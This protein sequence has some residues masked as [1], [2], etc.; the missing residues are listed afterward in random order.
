[1]RARH[2][3]KYQKN[4]IYVICRKN[5]VSEG[6]SKKHP[7]ILSKNFRI[8]IDSINQGVCVQYKFSFPH[9]QNP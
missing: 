2:Q 5:K 6:I 3:V 9:E 7:C 4:P 8:F 1:V